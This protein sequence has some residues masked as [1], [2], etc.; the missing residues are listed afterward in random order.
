MFTV[1]IPNSVK[2]DIK[3]L[4]KPVISKILE[5]LENLGQNPFQGSPLTG[6]FSN[7][8]KLELKHKGINYRIAYQINEDKI[9]IYILH[10]GTRENFYD[11]LKRRI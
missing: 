9:E 11:E 5:L 4:D 2:K 8:L 1:I 6:H 7:L 3:K 10:V